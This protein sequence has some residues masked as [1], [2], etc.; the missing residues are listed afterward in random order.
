MAHVLHDLSKAVGAA[1]QQRRP[2]LTHA[3]LNNDFPLV[4]GLTIE[5]SAVRLPID[6]SF[7]EQEGNNKEDKVWEPDQF[8]F[9]NPAWDTNIARI[10]EAV[11]PGL[12]LPAVRAF[13]RLIMSQIDHVPSFMK[14]KS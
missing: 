7:I 8:E 6:K 2:K 5:D 14:V 13:A 3:A 10:V 9:T 1:V 4:T 12:S 11:K